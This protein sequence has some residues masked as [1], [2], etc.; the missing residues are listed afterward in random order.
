MACERNTL[1]KRAKTLRDLYRETLMCYDDLKQ[2]GQLSSDAGE[3]LL[4]ADEV[5]FLED[6][7]K[8]TPCVVLFGELNSGKSSLVNALLREKVAPRGELP[9]TARL[10][11]FKYSET[12][13]ILLRDKHGIERKRETLDHERNNIKRWI[14]LNDDERRDQTEVSLAV[15]VAIENPLL[16]DGMLEIIDTPGLNENKELNNVVAEMCNKR[17]LL[18]LLVYVIDGN[19][20]VCSPD[21]K[22]IENLT[23]ECPNSVIIYVCSK[24]D[25]CSKAEMHN[26]PDDDELDDASDQLVELTPEQKMEGV[27]KTLVNEGV[28]DTNGGDMLNCKY[29]HGV[30][31]KRIEQ[32]RK[33][34]KEDMKSEDGLFV[35][36][37]NRFEEHIVE[38]V[39]SSLDSHFRQALRILLCSYEGCLSFLFQKELNLAQELETVPKLLDKAKMAENELTQVLLDFI[40][41]AETHMKLVD[42]VRGAI[43]RVKPDVLKD[44]MERKLPDKFVYDELANEPELSHLTM[45]IRSLTDSKSITAHAFCR[46]ICYV[47]VNRVTNET[48]K[49]T[50]KL[51]KDEFSTTLK[52]VLLT[53]ATLQMPGLS[54]VLEKDHIYGEQEED[55]DKNTTLALLVRMVNSISTGIRLA[56]VKEL[57]ETYSVADIAV[58]VELLKKQLGKKN[59]RSLR[60]E[61]ATGLVDVLKPTRLADAIRNACQLHI[62]TTHNNFVR[63]HER[64]CT[65]NRELCQRSQKQKNEITDFFV[66]MLSDLEVRCRALEY[67]I[68]YGVPMVGC[69]KIG[70]GGRNVVSKCRDQDRWCP[71]RD[72]LSL[73]IKSVKMEEKRG[74]GKTEMWYRTVVRLQEI[75]RL[76][77]HRNV[78]TVHGWVMPSPIKLYIIMDKVGN[79]LISSVRNLDRETKHEI[80]LDVATGLAYLHEQGIIYNDLKPQNILIMENEH[81]KRG[82]INIG[83]AEGLFDITPLGAPFHLAPFLY[84][85]PKQRRVYADMYAFGMLVWFLYDGRCRRPE[86]FARFTTNDMM[87]LAVFDKVLPEQPNN[88]DFYLWRLM[89][90]CWRGKKIVKADDLV[91]ILEQFGNGAGASTR[92]FA[93]KS[94]SV[95][96][97]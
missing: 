54:G 4:S 10:V 93:L 25:K 57:N 46:D 40:S 43:Q 33:H 74:R 2:K 19:Y 15:D 24:I 20:G 52:R 69:K 6:T 55:S 60:K 88:C 36:N 50:K 18:P 12:P 5:T 82:V 68:L 41:S 30:S 53:I 11:T 22:N 37:F 64:L 26:K 61:L 35:R 62:N 49:E 31:T 66:P 97:D 16:K 83:K 17:R 70:T 73:A 77:E 63:S 94:R 9:C 72:K 38:Y 79:N 1:N 51:L 48:H 42:V 58:R 21:R 7:L 23:K 13:F 39:R 47:I 89:K 91:K 56:V 87:K 90:E 67:E 8:Q 14:V 76:E 95:K 32:L 27:Y 80:A 28:I 96:K 65:L 34:S 59:E 71:D 86:A 75:R 45:I 84:E 29:F 78:I 92:S 85:H 44:A 3:A 81:G